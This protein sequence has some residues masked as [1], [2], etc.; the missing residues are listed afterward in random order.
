MFAISGYVAKMMGTAPRKPTHE[1]YA[2]AFVVIFRKGRR[3]KNTLIGRASIIMN[4]PIKILKVATG[5]NSA[6][7][8]KRPNVRNITIW[9]NHV[10][11]SKKVVRLFLCTTL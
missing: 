4:I 2:R 8:T 11:P 10:I 3:H 7:F 6:G 5:S 9:N 1:T